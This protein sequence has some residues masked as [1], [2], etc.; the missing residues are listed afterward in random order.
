MPTSGASLRFKYMEKWLEVVIGCV[1]GGI[2]LAIG[3]F[4]WLSHDR[5]GELAAQFAEFGVQ[6]DAKVVNTRITKQRVQTRREGIQVSFV[7][8][9]SYEFADL[10]G[11]VRRGESAVSEGEFKATRKGATIHVEYLRDNPGTN[12]IVRAASQPSGSNWPGWTMTGLGAILCLGAVAGFS[13]DFVKAGRRAHVVRHGSPFL[14]WVDE[15]VEHPQ[16]KGASKYT[17]SFAF[18]DPDCDDS[19]GWI[20]LPARLSNVWKSGDPILVLWDGREDSYAEP[21]IFGIRTEDLH[22]LQN[23]SGVSSEPSRRKIRHRKT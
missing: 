14:G 7:F 12:R 2:F 3:A 13:Y 16:E 4:A 15:I 21:D 19:E 22:H 9:V 11:S 6:A 10:A 1:F 8:L 5:A 23:E 20:W 18:K 17:F